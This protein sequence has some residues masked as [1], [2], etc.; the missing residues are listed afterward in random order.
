MD[1]SAKLKGN[2]TENICVSILE[3]AGYRVTH[4]GIEKTLKDLSFLTQDKYL[5]L[6]LTDTLRL[7]PDLIVAELDMSAVWLVEVKYRKNFKSFIGYGELYEKLKRQAE[8]WGDFWVLIFVNE[9]EEE[10]IRIRLE[11]EVFREPGSKIVEF[12]GDYCGVL[13]VGLFEDGKTLGFYKKTD[14]TLLKWSKLK[15]RDLSRI[16]SVFAKVG[17]KATSGSPIEKSMRIV[18]EFHKLT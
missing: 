8:A 9:P 12:A 10:I 17:A 3:D 16:G 7:M 13:K 15:W 14:N 18:R 11:S 6:G 2:L 4:F 1:F 5:S